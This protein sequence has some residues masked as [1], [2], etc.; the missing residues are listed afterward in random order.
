MTRSLA[1]G[2]GNTGGSYNGNFR[3]SSNF[4][5]RD[6]RNNFNNKNNQTIDQNYN[7]NSNIG[8]RSSSSYKPNNTMSLFRP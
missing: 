1:N 8:G 4:N 3:D 5:N 6:D 2:F 7:G